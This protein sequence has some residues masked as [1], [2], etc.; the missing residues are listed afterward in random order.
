MRVRFCRLAALLGAGIVCSGQPVAAQTADIADRSALKVCADPNNL[1]FS[2]EKKE[3]FENK[4]AELMGNSLGIKVEY[5]WFPQ[6]IGFVRN[7]L[8]TYRCDLVI[9]TVAGDEIMQTTNPY[10]FTTYV[11]VYRSD[12]GMAIDG[13]QDPRLKSLRLGVVSATPPSDLLVRH[14]LMSRTKPYPL[15]V[16]TRVESPT[17]QMVQDIVDGTIDL[18]FLWGP[19]AGYYKKHDKLPLTLIPLADEQGAAR[20]RY[21]IAMGVRGNEPEWR[22]KINAVILKQQ[23][24]I[25]AILRDYGVPLLNEQGELIDP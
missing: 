16:D 10:Y 21:H 11:M 15:T 6:I 4:I 13:V 23:P 14:D 12:K 1:P 24:Q 17:H 20:M 22:R 2:D 8:Q 19:I 25:T 18:G 9:G 3:G 5:T 7:T